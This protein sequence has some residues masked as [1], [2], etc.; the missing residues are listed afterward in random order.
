MRKLSKSE[1]EMQ[2]AYKTD[3]LTMSTEMYQKGWKDG[4]RQG[5][6]LLPWKHGCAI[7]VSG[8]IIGALSMWVA[9]TQ[10]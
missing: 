9:I 7:Y 8:M 5:T 6:D 4:L 2:S 3:S 1:D 10:F